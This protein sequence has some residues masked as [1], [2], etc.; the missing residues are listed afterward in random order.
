[1]NIVS[2][3]K[4]IGIVLGSVTAFIT[5]VS[6]MVMYKPFAS[7]VV[8]IGIAAIVI[9]LLWSWIMIIYDNIEDKNRGYWDN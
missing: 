5:F 2:L 6:L 9:A 3:A 7:I 1:M 8:I 4:A